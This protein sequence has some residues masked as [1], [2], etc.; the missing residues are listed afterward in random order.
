[1]PTKKKQDKMSWSFL[2]LDSLHYLNAQ[3]YEE[4]AF[5]V[6]STSPAPLIC[7]IKPKWFPL[8]SACDS[9]H[10][11]MWHVSTGSTSARCLQRNNTA[12]SWEKIK[13]DTIHA[14]SVPSVCRRPDLQN[15]ILQDLLKIIS[16]ERHP[17]IL[18]T[19]DA[20]VTVQCCETG[21]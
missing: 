4:S 9:M 21:F 20:W 17:V 7:Y 10:I 16:I 13:Q 15:C 2:I 3:K 8:C 1:M 14:P 6:F 19:V 18:N 12:F 5:Q 11:H